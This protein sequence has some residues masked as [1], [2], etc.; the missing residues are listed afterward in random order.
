MF[1]KDKQIRAAFRKVQH[2]FEEHLD[3]IN[4]NSSEIHENRAMIME[5]QERIC[6][7]S[8]QI[9]EM[10]MMVEQ[11][12][13]D[14]GFGE[15]GPLTLREQEVFLLLYTAGD[16]VTH[17]QIARTSSLPVSLVKEIVSSCSAKGI[18]VRR[19]TNESGITYL[20]LDPAF[21]ER[22]ARE[23]IL[24]ID[25]SLSQQLSKDFQLSLLDDA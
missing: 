2:E 1:R 19:H 9:S 17:E 6:K 18:P 16:L 13:P 12:F 22:Q 20:S 8:D 5:L 7:V 15:L 25:E 10:Q 14:E 11:M 3:S 23:N 4:A 21:R 24:G